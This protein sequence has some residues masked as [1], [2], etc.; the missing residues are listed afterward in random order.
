MEIDMME[1]VGILAG[2][3]TTASFVPQV[4]HSWRTK[5]VE[6]ISLRMYLLLCFGIILWLV[7]GFN[8]GS[9][10]LILAN[11]VTFVLTVAI[12][13]MKIRY[14]RLSRKSIDRNP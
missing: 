5:S 3:C 2:C 7:Y 14:G 10:S 9:F 12:L 4:L 13:I 6:D 11:G 1:L 8:I